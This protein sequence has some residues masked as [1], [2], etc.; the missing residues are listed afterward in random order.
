[1]GQS[2]EMATVTGVRS[3][4]SA[5]AIQAADMVHYVCVEGA[6]GGGQQALGTSDWESHCLWQAVVHA[7]LLF[8][9]IKQFS[10]GPPWAVWPEGEGPDVLASMGRHCLRIL[11]LTRWVG[12]ATK[13][14]E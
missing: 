9:E 3:G 4:A 11:F 5:L 8:G 12:R 7:G 1:M 10:H 14:L 2:L 13:G 6:G